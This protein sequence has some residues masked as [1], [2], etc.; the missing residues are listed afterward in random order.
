MHDAV[1]GFTNGRIADGPL[2]VNN[3]RETETFFDRSV[4]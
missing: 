4:V 1:A 3:N 2:K